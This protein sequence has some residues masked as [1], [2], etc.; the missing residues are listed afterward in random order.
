MPQGVLGFTIRSAPTY[1]FILIY[2]KLVLGKLMRFKP[3][4]LLG[5]FILCS[6]LA[7]SADLKTEYKAACLHPLTQ[8]HLKT[9]VEFLSSDSLEGRLTGSHGEVLATQ[10]VAN[11]FRNLGLEPVGDKGTF[12]QEYSFTA[13]VYLGKNNRLS[14]TIR[15]ERPEICN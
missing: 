2:S 6:G 11:V 9:H 12:F 8:K 15:M 7:L 5:L 13:G 10:Y 14:I 3:C 1:A 4:T